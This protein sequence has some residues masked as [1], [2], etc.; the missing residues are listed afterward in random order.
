MAGKNS[1]CTDEYFATIRAQF[2]RFEDPLVYTPGDNERTDCNVFSKNNGLYTPTERLAAVR[3]L[4]FPVPGQTLGGRKKR[5]L[6]QAD[7]PANS[8]F[9][10]NVMWMESQVVVSALNITGSNNDLA[11]WGAPLPANAGQFPSQADEQ[12][13]RAQA[14]AAWLQ[15]TFALANTNNA[16]GVALTLQADM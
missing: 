8:T 2:D 12:A 10:E 9:V 4:F 11:A 7:D 14:N 6:T 15:K 16:A 3:A 1:P 13:A 5:V